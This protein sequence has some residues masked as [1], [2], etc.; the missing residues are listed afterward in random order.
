MDLL[1]V[2]K[3]L[4]KQQFEG[5]ELIGFETRNKYLLMDENQNKIGFAAEQQ[6]GFFGAIWRQFLGHWRTFDV[7]FFNEDKAEFMIAHHPFRFFFQRFEITDSSGQYL[8]A[9]Q[10]RFSILT[11]RFDLVD[12]TNKVIFEMKSPF[13]RI[14]TFPFFKNDIEV[15]RVEKKWGGL[16]TEAFTDKDSFMVSYGDPSLTQ[17]QRLIILASSVFVDLQYF[18]KKARV[19]ND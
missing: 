16:L 11:K 6:K 12:R 17:Q 9:L 4:I 19:N 15:A 3:V 13:W 1:T 8:G 7:H 10:Q 18:E 2:N 5:F 14:W